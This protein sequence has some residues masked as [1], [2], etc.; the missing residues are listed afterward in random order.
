MD[1]VLILAG[2]RTPIGRATRGAYNRTHGATLAGHAIEHAVARSG[3]DP[4]E[5][6]DVVLGVGMPEGATGHNLARNAA[7]RAG[8][9]VGVAGTTIN[10]YCASG[11][12]A[13]ASAAH[14][15]AFD[16]VPVVVA[17]GAE[18]ISLVQ[19]TLNV[20]H[21]TEERLLRD[22]ADLWMSML[23]TADN[24][25]TRYGVSREAQ[26]AYAL[27]SQRRTAEAQTAG[28]FD[29]EIVPLTTWKSEVDKA[30]DTAREVETTLTRDEGNRPET[31]LEA[32]LGLKGV[33][34]LASGLEDDDHRGQLEPALRRR[35]GRRARERAVREPPRFTGARR[36]PRVRR[37]GRVSGRDGRRPRARRA[38][39]ART[40]RAHGGRRRP[41][42]AQRGVRRADALL[43]RRARH[44][45]RAAQRRRRRDLRRPSRTA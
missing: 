23:Q 30:T 35:G 44:P 32:L 19:P 7:L 17:G 21:Y 18:S 13:I 29:A 10:R 2:A 45:E 15:V 34:G 36:V 20:N 40:P 5:I 22:H 1:D 42:G 39:A 27:E 28:R 16:G 31:T 33:P 12:Q 11:L 43:P 37:R 41:V 9:G 6:D 24:V 25:A 38:E 8:L 26:D 4:V 14:H 3:V